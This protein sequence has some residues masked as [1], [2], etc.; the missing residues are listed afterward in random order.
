MR[1]ITIPG[2]GCKTP[3]PIGRQGENEAEKVRFI[4]TGYKETYGDGIATLVVDFGA[5]YIAVT[6]QTEEALE[7]VITRADT[8][9]EGRGYAELSWTV[10]GAV[11]KSV[12]FPI[13]VAHSVSGSDI[14]PPD[15]MQSWLDALI[16]LGAVVR[17]DAE[18]ADQSARDAAQNAIYAESY[19]TAA[20]Q[21]AADASTAKEKA[22]A[23][24]AAAEMAET[25]AT[26]AAAEAGDDAMRAGESE[27]AA[28]AAQR[29]A[30][31]AAENAE[32]SEE[33]AAR[34]AAS[35]R[36]DKEEASEAAS[37]AEAA[38]RDITGMAEEI[39]EYA[40]EAARSAE[41]AAIDA[42]EAEAA[43]AETQRLKE[44]TQEIAEGIPGALEE[45][46]AKLEDLDSR[47]MEKHLLEYDGTTISEADAPLTFGQLY[48]ILMNSEDFAVLVYSNYA[49]HPNGVSTEQIVFSSSYPVNGMDV[50][51]RITMLRNGTITRTDATDENLINKAGAITDLNKDDAI[52]YPSIKAVTGY[53]ASKADTYT[54]GEVDEEIAKAT[55]NAQRVIENHIRATPDYGMYTV[56][57]PKWETSH[58]SGGEKLDDNQGLVL[59]PATDTTKEVNTY[60]H[61]FDTLDVNA[62][63]DD[64]G[65][66]HITAIKGDKDFRDTG[67][68]DVFVCFRTYWER[69]W[70]EGGYEY[71][72]RCYYPRDGYTVVSLA[73]NKDGSI[74][75]WFLIAKYMA[76]DILD[77][78]SAHTHELYSS[79]GL[80]PAHY[81]GAATGDEE[82][83]D[84]ISW[85][86]MQSIFKRRGK[87]YTG[88]LLAELKHFTTSMWL[89][90]ATKNSQGVMYGYGNSS[91][92]YICA[93]PTADANRFAV[94]AA[95]AGNIDLLQCVTIGDNG[96]TTAPD[97]NTGACHNIAYD[98]RVIGKETLE[99]GNVAIIVDH[100]PFT[101]TPTSWIS[102][103]H[104]LSGYSDFILGRTGSPTSNANGRHGMVL[105]GV[106]LMAGGYETIGNAILNAT[107]D[108]LV[109]DIVLT[110]DA[111]K[112]TTNVAAFIT[113]G[114]VASVKSRV[115]TTGAWNYV[116][117]VGMDLDNG[118][119]ANTQAGGS[120]SGSSYGY[121]DGQYF[122]AIT[123]GQREL[124]CLG[125]LWYGSLAGLCY[126]DGSPGVTSASWYIL[127]RLSINACWG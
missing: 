41:S 4:L 88:S 52:K 36:A 17:E 96:L 114:I 79:K 67:R 117:E 92:Q 72:S 126:V 59:T 24:A 71:Y 64:D 43:R 105:D 40:A 31:S 77:D 42:G 11:A 22:E 124:L 121:A 102:S 115:T 58:T 108:P 116:T 26:A 112:L 29:A 55:P 109:R 21:M 1:V 125:Y 35:A 8:A 90:F 104:E 75:P 62:Y 76:G 30:E 65:I 12:T 70:E 2:C 51:H 91:I 7:W 85:S 87:Y 97:R 111:T 122:D 78:D 99:S 18:A 118:A 37:S 100:A 98:V 38:K 83:S 123:S 20:G 44:E 9:K 15:P 80:R 23:A 34:D 28:Q 48:D 50:N 127:A 107:A 19:A 113:S 32:A 101:T 120:G 119:I 53:A 74:N 6:E 39:G 106:E 5:P 94:T 73:K 95:Q 84:S 86:G 3:I 89:Y 25:A 47:K 93:E 68:V 14:E 13:A 82:I 103:F 63:I 54:K 57:F 60:P 46:N 33:S 49:Y 27:R 66:R 61:C 10:G 56:R 69:Y 81:I 110:N 45:V 16:A